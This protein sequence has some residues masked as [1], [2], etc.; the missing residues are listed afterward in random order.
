MLQIETN[1]KADAMYIKLLDE[2]IGYSQE[3]DA[4]RVIDYT[5]NPGKP[6]GIDLLAVSRGVKITGLPEVKG[7]DLEKLLTSLGIKVIQ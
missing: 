1:T 7:V 5:L 6:V 2:P 4:N 3:L